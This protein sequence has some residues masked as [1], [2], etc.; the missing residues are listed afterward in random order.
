MAF[1]YTFK[2]QIMN[3][4]AFKIK[5]ILYLSMIKKSIFHDP[6]KNLYKKLKF[7]LLE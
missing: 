5:I 2:Q 6:I 4:L 7:Y 1:L 3:I